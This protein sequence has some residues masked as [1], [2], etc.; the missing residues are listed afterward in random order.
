MSERNPYSGPCKTCGCQRPAGL[1]SAIARRAAL[2]EKY[3]GMI[4]DNLRWHSEG[5]LN[6]EHM[7]SCVNNAMHYW[8]VD[9]EA[10]GS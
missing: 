2:D 8:H 1:D 3:I 6:W 4:N 7:K 9:R 5:K 10:I